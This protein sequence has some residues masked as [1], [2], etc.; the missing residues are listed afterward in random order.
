MHLE[1]TACPTG[2]I[3]CAKH[4]TEIVLPHPQG[5]LK[6]PHL[7]QRPCWPKIYLGLHW[8]SHKYF[9]RC[10]TRDWVVFLGVPCRCL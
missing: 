9:F 4:L 2:R 6:P 3:L 7:V 8:R 5:S 10:A 1:R